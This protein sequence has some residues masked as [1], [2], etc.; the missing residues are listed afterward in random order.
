MKQKQRINRR[1]LYLVV[2]STTTLF[3]FLTYNFINWCGAK[4]PK[5]LVDTYVRALE[6]KDQSLMLRLVP[7][8]YYSEQEVQDKVMKL[9]GHDIQEIQVSYKKI[10][11]HIATAT[12]EGWYVDS[13]GKPVNFKDIINLRYESGSFL[14]S[15]KGRWYLNLG[16]SKNPVNLVPAS[17]PF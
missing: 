3:L 7:E 1:L 16:R 11:P 14:V 5:D 15:Y 6:N 4:T 8:S 13:K 2:I 9:G 10:K 12:I 17:T